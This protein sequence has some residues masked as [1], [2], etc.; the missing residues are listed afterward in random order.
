MAAADQKIHDE[1]NER[2]KAE[3]ELGRLAGER[4]TSDG[5]KQVGQR[6]VTDHGMA[7]EEL[8]RLAQ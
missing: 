7:N 5:V 6:M 1:G 4:G 3:V 2:G 8:S